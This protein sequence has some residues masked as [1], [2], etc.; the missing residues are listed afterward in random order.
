[1]LWPSDNQAMAGMGI[2]FTVACPKQHNA[3]LV[4]ARGLSGDYS[5]LVN[6]R[7]AG[8]MFEAAASRVAQTAGY[9]FEPRGRAGAWMTPVEA[10]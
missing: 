6:N 2:A 7:L 3:A 4:V 5:P 1:M 10:L 8:E 9:R